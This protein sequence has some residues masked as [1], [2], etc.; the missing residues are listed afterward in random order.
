MSGSHLSK[1]FFDLVKAIGESK[2]KQ[3]ED[4]IIVNEVR[5]LK[6]RFAG[7]SLSKKVIKESLVRM[8]YVEMLGHD[9]SFAYVHAI[10]LTASGDLMQK[11]V[12]YLTASLTLSPEDQ[13]RFMLVNQLQRDLASANILEV[14]TALIALSKLIT[15]EMIPALL[16]SVSKLLSHENS[17]VRKKAILSLHRIY[18]LDSDAVSHL[19]ENFRRVLCDKDPSVMGASLCILH[20]IIK[21]DPPGQKDLVP[22]F[23][24]I[25]KQ[26][27][28]HRLPKD[29]DYHRI[30]APWIQI[31]LLKLLA[32]LG[33]NDQRASEQMYEVIGDCMK[34]ANTGIYVGYAIIYECVRTVTTIYPN[35]PL[36]DAAAGAIARFIQS[37]SHNLKYLG[38]TGLASIV[39]DHPRYAAE[40]QMVVLD[41]LEDPDE[42]L[43]R[44][45]LDLLFRMTN[46]VN[47]EVVVDK[48]VFFLRTAVDKFL[49]QDLVTRICQLAERYAPNNL[50]YIRTISKVFELGG[51]LVEE[52]IAHNLLRLLAEGAGEEG[53][54]YENEENPDE[55]MRREAC[56][57]FYDNFERSK[58]PDIL[59]R[60]MFW[61]LGEYSYLMGTEI[62]PEV[63]EVI[64]E[65]ARRQGM[66]ADTRGYA[67]TAVLKIC[68]QLGRLPSDAA[69]LIDH[70]GSSID[71]DLQQKCYEFREIARN[72]NTLTEVLP[73]DASCED[74]S[75]PD[76][77]FLDAYVDEE[78][79]NGKS[80]Y[81]PPSVDEAAALEYDDDE[82]AA[83]PKIT[84]EP[85]LKYDAYEKPTAPT[86]IAS[87]TGNFSLSYGAPS[88]SGSDSNGTGASASSITLGSGA[89]SNGLNLQGVKSVWGSSGYAGGPSATPQPTSTPEPESHM[90][91]HANSMD[92]YSQS[93]QNQQS[94]P[95]QRE[96]SPSPAPAAPE[97]PKPRQITERERMAAALFGGV[98][99]DAGLSGVSGYSASA[100]PPRTGPMRK[101]ASAGVS[102]AAPATSPPS[103][104][105]TGIDLLGFGDS[106]DDVA[107]ANNSHSTSTQAQDNSMDLLSAFDS[108]PS[109]GGSSDFLG[110]FG[111]NSTSAP[112]PPPF[113]PV[114][115]Q[116]QNFGQRWVSNP[117]ESRF[118]VVLQGISSIRD[119]ASRITS[120][121]G[122]NCIEVIEQ[123]Q[124]AIFAGTDSNTYDLALVHAKRGPTG[125]DL[126]VRSKDAA[127]TGRIAQHCRSLLR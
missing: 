6:T 49:R 22:S 95:S 85:S 42:T 77:S 127:T 93:L 91:A 33:A 5:T 16:P 120:K 103:S 96:P 104:T 101:R 86:Q 62:L 12:G 8:I 45:T 1:D 87:S 10:Q 112:A 13:F 82:L 125:A 4:R 88:G 100:P 60:V 28:E 117:A 7:K 17:A 58:L 122:L 70:Y 63:L 26:I 47:A 21:N 102:N 11:K 105:D 35:A 30:P 55:V 43:K 75:D 121:L 106:S 61:T 116:T 20:D 80:D 24:S 124:E 14:S 37:D 36:L 115:L 98:S 66:A 54:G 114:Q 97:P 84:S 71:I 65:A 108:G 57:I 123:T 94:E 34:R 9:A 78:R 59:L 113:S 53:D 72:P 92:S 31:K 69:D 23:V 90:P 67:V 79:A 107:S 56:I 3:E 110:S 74:L 19:N 68:A 89:T 25:L 51:D 73:V 52:E 118:A 38:V 119:V 76:F 44:K 2:S 109:G 99:S 18:Q 81:A 29:F 39:R 40:H 32:T 48:L 111:G 64:C 46:P 126:I 27:I 15:G 41:C 83:R 50:W